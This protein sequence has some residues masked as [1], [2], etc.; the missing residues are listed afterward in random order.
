MSE[1]VRQQWERENRS[2][3]WTRNVQA[4]IKPWLHDVRSFRFERGGRAYRAVSHRGGS[5]ELY[6][7]GPDGLETFA[8]YAWQLLGRIDDRMKNAGASPVNNC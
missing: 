8:G 6:A 1:T 7:I 3:L 2:A 5:L 4:M